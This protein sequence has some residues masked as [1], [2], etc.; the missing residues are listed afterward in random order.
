MQFTTITKTMK[1]VVLMREYQP[2]TIAN[3][4]NLTHPK[5]DFTRHIFTGGN[6]SQS[7]K[8]F[9]KP[10]WKFN[11][12]NLFKIHPEFVSQLSTLFNRKRL[13]SYEFSYQVIPKCAV[14]VVKTR[15]SHFGATV[16]VTLKL[17]LRL[18]CSSPRGFLCFLFSKQKTTFNSWA[19]LF[20]TKSGNG[21]SGHVTTIHTWS[22]WNRWFERVLLQIINL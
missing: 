22:C 5:N 9:F 18:A 8:R 12:S 4:S 14:K 10:S 7:Q 19:N 17:F 13:R 15:D 1:K 2:V 16:F 21:K 20:E 6:F 11:L 3:F